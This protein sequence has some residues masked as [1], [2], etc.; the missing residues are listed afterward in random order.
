MSEASELCNDL[1]MAI[2]DLI[3]TFVTGHDLPV[4]LVVGTLEC[5]KHEIILDHSPLQATLLDLGFEEIED[6]DDDDDW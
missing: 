3:D 6:E 1:G 5:I 2:R 4:A